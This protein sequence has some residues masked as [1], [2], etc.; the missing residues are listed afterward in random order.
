MINKLITEDDLYGAVDAAFA[1]GW[2]RI[3]LY[4]LI[5]LPT[6]TDEDT[7]GIAEL[8]RNCVALGRRHR[9]GRASVTA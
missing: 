6:E 4:F 5:G 3:K 1:E 8:A 9:G 2:S 7:R